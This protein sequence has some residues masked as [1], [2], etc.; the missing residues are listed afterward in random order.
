MIE[1]NMPLP[2]GFPLTSLFGLRDRFQRRVSDTLGVRIWARGNDVYFSGGDQAVEMAVELFRIM[3]EKIIKRG[4]VTDDDVQC[5]LSQVVEDEIADTVGRIPPFEVMNGRRFRPRTAGQAR[6]VKAIME[7]EVVFGIG[8]AGTGKTYLAVA[9]AVAAMK[10]GKIKRLVLVRP[11]V[12]AGENLGFL[13]GDLKA[14]IDPYLRPIFDALRDMMDPLLLRRMT[15]E[16]VIEMSPLAYMRGR[17]LNDAF[18]ILDEAQ[19]TT[20]SQMKMFLTR[21]GNNSRVII[22]GD[23]TQVDLPRNTPSGLVDAIRRLEG[24]PNIAVVEMGEMDVV[25]HDLVQKI[26]RAYEEPEKVPEKRDSYFS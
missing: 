1:K 5:L 8:P 12:E 16:E 2:E 25:R 21:M 11:A 17:T 20:V 14:K 10:A 24:I 6:Y 18:I 22:S 13:P 19:N 7:N 26:I 4:E 15:E 23:V 3:K 9:A